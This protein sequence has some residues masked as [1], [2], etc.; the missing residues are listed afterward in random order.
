MHAKLALR[1]MKFII[2]TLLHNYV[3][4][5]LMLTKFNKSNNYRNKILT[6]INPNV[7]MHITLK[8]AQHY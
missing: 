7:K 3:N 5:G 1:H 6:I 4:E 8:L 2:N